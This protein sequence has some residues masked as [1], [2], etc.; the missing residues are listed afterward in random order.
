MFTQECLESE[1]EQRG[2]GAGRQ[3][4]RAVTREPEPE[5]DRE[6]RDEERLRD[7]RDTRHRAARGRAVRVRGEL[8][9]DVWEILTSY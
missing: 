5:S 9:G 1:E 3:R 2:A 7:R 8:E 4:V 6:S